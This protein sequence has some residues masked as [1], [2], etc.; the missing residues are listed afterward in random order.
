MTGIVCPPRVHC[1]NAKTGSA[2]LLKGIL[3]VLALLH[4]AASY[5]AVDLNKAT[6]ADMDGTEGIG[7]A[8]AGDAKPAAAAAPAPADAKTAA[9][10]PK[11]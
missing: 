3:A 9:S 8:L 7:L 5:S 2:V 4:A 6:A 11:K 1:V 10:A